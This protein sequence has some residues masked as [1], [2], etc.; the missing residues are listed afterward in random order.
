MLNGISATAA[1]NDKEISLACLRSVAAF[2]NSTM[3]NEMES[4]PLD[5]VSI[6]AQDF[7]HFKAVV[8][9]GSFVSL[10][11]DHK[12]SVNYA[13]SLTPHAWQMSVL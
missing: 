12:L 6:R 9:G 1:G 2:L 3:A 13:R 7:Q 4:Q 11:Y 5:L 8:G 10:R